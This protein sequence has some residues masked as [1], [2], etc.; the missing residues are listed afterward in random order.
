MNAISPSA[1]LAAQ[2][3]RYAT[4]KFDPSFLIPED[5]L[6]AL[7]QSLRLTASSF[8]LQPWKFIEVDSP[9][10]RA[11]LQAASWHQTQIT[12]ASKLFVLSRPAAFGKAD[13]AR[14]IEATA[15]ARNIPVDSLVGYHQTMEG[16]LAAMDPSALDFW[17]EK[18]SYIALGN[19]LTSAALLGLDACP[20]EGISRT[21][22]DRIL[23]LES[24]GLR[25]LVVCAVG[26]RASDDK[27]ASLA[28]VRYNEEEVFLKL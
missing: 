7:R 1:L 18:Q 11:A 13:V 26:R 16:F 3:F 25:S 20:I 9:E 12:Q 17:M 21:D 22:Y 24:H 28:K 2:N 14:F 19:L 5:Q 27:Y 23:G 10:K 8:G 15:R 6:H 4:K